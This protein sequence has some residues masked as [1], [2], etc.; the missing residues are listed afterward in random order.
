MDRRRIARLPRLTGVTFAGRSPTFK[1]VGRPELTG[2]P[3][4]S[5]ECIDPVLVPRRTKGAPTENRFKVDR[6]RGTKS[7]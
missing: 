7:S 5:V 1:K 6:L 2:R 3:W 4:V